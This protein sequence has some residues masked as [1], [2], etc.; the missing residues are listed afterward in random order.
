MCEKLSYQII[1][2][3]AVK[4]EVYKSHYRKEN[5]SVGGQGREALF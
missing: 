5:N 4:L 2:I 3:S 1:Y